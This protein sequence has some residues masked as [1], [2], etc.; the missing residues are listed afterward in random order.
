MLNSWKTEILL[1]LRTL[2]MLLGSILQKK[3]AANR[4]RKCKPDPLAAK[5]RPV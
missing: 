1:D 5:V 4:A 3:L 2:S